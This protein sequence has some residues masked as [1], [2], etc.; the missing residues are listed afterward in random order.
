MSSS[1][2]TCW[3]V[4]IFYAQLSERPRCLNG[5]KDPENAEQTRWEQ[6]VIPELSLRL[7]PTHTSHISTDLIIT[8][9]R[10]ELPVNCLFYSGLC[11]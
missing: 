6:K 3:C 4:Q 5:L 10:A 7:P 11:I 8:Q 1:A 9:K 2:G